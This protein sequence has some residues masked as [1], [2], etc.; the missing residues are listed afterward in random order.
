MMRFLGLLGVLSLS[1]AMAG[2][3]SH[4]NARI[5]SVS[6]QADICSEL[7]LANETPIIIDTQQCIKRG[8]FKAYERFVTEFEGNSLT[9]LMRVKVIVGALQ[10]R[11]K[12]RREFKTMVVDFT[13]EIT[14]KPA[15][16][17]VISVSECKSD[18][19]Y[20]I[21][22]ARP[23]HR[24]VKYLSTSRFNLLKEEVKENIKKTDLSIELGDGYYDYLS[25]AY[26]II[27]SKNEV[28]GY[29]EKSKLNYHET[30][31]RIT[32]L[33]RYNIKGERIGE[34]EVY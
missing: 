3:W 15:G 2:Q 8:S 26:Y 19:D 23:G 24:N 12:L 6:T 22:R 29:L 31:D 34:V 11:S 16:W 4:T 14:V 28:V 1:T 25:T 10:C 21:L 13:G 33:V 9:T 5:H 27:V 18:V 20:R 17:K 30:T 32:A 7:V